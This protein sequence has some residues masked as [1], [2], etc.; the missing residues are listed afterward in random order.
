MG[1]N[2][3]LNGCGVFYTIKYRYFAFSSAMD[4]F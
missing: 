2:M 3:R 4:V 1:L